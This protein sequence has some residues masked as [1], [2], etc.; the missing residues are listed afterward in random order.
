MIHDL[1]TYSLVLEVNR[2][3]YSQFAEDAP[4]TL[5]R[6]VAKAIAF[7]YITE[8]WYHSNEKWENNGD[9]HPHLHIFCQIPG[10]KE[11]QWLLGLQHQLRK[12]D[13]HGVFSFSNFAEW[14]KPEDFEVFEGGIYPHLLYLSGDN[15]TPRPTSPVLIYRCGTPTGIGTNLVTAGHK[16]FNA[17]LLE[18]ERY[19]NLPTER[20]QI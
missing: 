11:R 4:R 9:F 15:W 19:K 14:T 5:M 16:N 7:S 13:R 17:P 3:H 20:N 2:Q 6:K 8:A 10:F 18:P 12:V 1:Q